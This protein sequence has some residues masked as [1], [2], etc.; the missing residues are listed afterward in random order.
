MFHPQINHETSS[1]WLFA[2]C[3]VHGSI[4]VHR[5]GVTPSSLRPQVSMNRVM[6]RTYTTYCQQALF[7]PLAAVISVKFPVL[8]LLSPP[9][10][11][12]YAR[13]TTQAWY[14]IQLSLKMSPNA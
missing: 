11:F 2:L 9:I 3:I 6:M 10:H 4:A 8:S 12:G 14:K 13:R 7:P 5:A 1:L